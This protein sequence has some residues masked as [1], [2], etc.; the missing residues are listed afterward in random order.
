MSIS[1]TGSRPAA[2]NMRRC[3]AGAIA[4]SCWP[5][6]YACGGRANASLVAPST[7][8]RCVT[9]ASGCGRSCGAAQLACGSVQQFVERVLGWLGRQGRAWRALLHDQ[10]GLHLIAGRIV[11]PAPEVDRLRV[12]ARS[13]EARKHA[14]P[15]PAPAERTVDQQDL[16]HV[17]LSLSEVAGTGPIVFARLSCAASGERSRASRL[18]IRSKWC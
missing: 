15:A 4:R 16:R 11:T 9:V 14:L 8:T 2:A 17:F 18:A 6:T 3:I 10:V 1:I 5:V 12:V 13:S 7:L